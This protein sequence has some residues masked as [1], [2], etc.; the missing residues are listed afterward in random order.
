MQVI[1]IILILETLGAVI[2]SEFTWGKLRQKLN[3]GKLLEAVIRKSNE[4]GATS[5]SNLCH[6]R[7]FP[8]ASLP[9]RA[10]H[11]YSA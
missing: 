9:K 1:R 6:L 7:I 4:R 2:D 11:A 10:L 8:L 3:S 5:L